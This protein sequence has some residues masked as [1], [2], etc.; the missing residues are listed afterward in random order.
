MKRELN[1]IWTEALHRNNKHKGFILKYRDL[2][3]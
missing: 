1:D 3:F 2:D